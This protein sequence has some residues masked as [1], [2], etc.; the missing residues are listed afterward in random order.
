MATISVEQSRALPEG[1]E[2]ISLV[3]ASGGLRYIHPMEADDD[4][5]WAIYDSRRAPGT[6]YSYELMVQHVAENWAA[7]IRRVHGKRLPLAVA[8]RRR[9]SASIDSLPAAV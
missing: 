4:H 5:W 2:T 3:R 7:N 9:H 8:T 6:A 1:V